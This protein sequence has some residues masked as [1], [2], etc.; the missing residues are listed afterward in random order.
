MADRFMVE[1][2]TQGEWAWLLAIYLFI[3][4]L[5]GALY[6]FVWAL[7]LPS[8]LALVSIGL[9]LLGAFALLLKLGNPLRAWRAASRPGTSWISRGVLSV[10]SFILFAVLA[11]APD[12]VT[13][14]QLPWSAD[15]ALGRAL[16]AIAALAALATAIYPGFVVAGSRAIAFW[17]TPMLPLLFFTYA[18][19][20]ASGIVLIASTPATLPRVELLAGGLIAVN[21]VLL[22][23][24]LFTMSKAGAGARELVRRLNRAPLRETCWLGVVLVGLLLPLMLVGWFHAHAEIAGACILAGGLL[25]RYCVLKAGVYDVPTALAPAGMDFS[26]LNR[27]SSDFEREYRAARPAARG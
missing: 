24:Y 16:A 23:I 22:A 1:T 20:G 15:S 12:Y 13:V 9:V 18:L 5:G 3:G 6:L 14:P 11:L 8:V 17:R 27:T 19:M 25:F 26:K 4:S 2:H 21:I 10:S 7:A